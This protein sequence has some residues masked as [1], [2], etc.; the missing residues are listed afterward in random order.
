M[1]RFLF[2][3]LALTAFTLAADL[4][5]SRLKYEKEIA[6]SL[7]FTLSKVIARE[8]YQ[9][10]VNLAIS[11]DKKELSS[12]VKEFEK[13][14]KK[15]HPNALPGFEQRQTPEDAEKEILSHIHFEPTISVDS[16]SVILL[17]HKDI[18]AEKKTLATSIIKKKIQTNYGK[19]ASVEVKETA[20]DNLK[21]SKIEPVIETLTHP[22]DH[23]LFIPAIALG[24]F[25]L[26]L[27]LWLI[28][29]LRRK[30]AKLEIVNDD[31][32]IIPEIKKEPKSF[33]QS[34]QKIIDF[35]IIDGPSFREFYH[36]LPRRHQ[37]IVGLI[38][39]QTPL[40]NLTAEIAGLNFESSGEDI[41]D[42]E[43][44][45]ALNDTCSHI[46]NFR[47]LHQVVKDRPFGFVE[48]FHS[49]KIVALLAQHSPEDVA[50]VINSLDKVFVQ[51]ILKNMKLETKA[52]IL[53]ISSKP[54]LLNSL[55]KRASELEKELRLE[56][57]DE[58]F[59][60]SPITTSSLVHCIIDNDNDLSQTLAVAKLS[61]DFVNKFSLKKYLMNFEDLLS[62]DPEKI[63]ELINHLPNEIIA[64]ALRDENRSSVE[65]S[66]KNLSKL[67]RKVIDNLMLSGVLDPSAKKEAQNRFM[68]EY[69]R[70]M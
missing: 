26:L 13:S 7:E 56:I 59:K 68:K 45:I 55:A 41:S 52:K 25:L 35:A 2:I 50:I 34:I 38:L 40:T 47:R 28:Y 58:K 12:E 53:E 19:A 10:I 66:L 60:F 32:K 30:K 57:L 18:D 70:K 3:I 24:A 20:F 48:G 54:E 42:E 5:E 61:D 17:L 67:R 63:A 16:I 43:K 64:V 51:E 22:K 6:E 29:L 49:E 46:E 62:S 21:P 8:S 39:Q 65:K 36:S 1:K 37:E 69:R 4:E 27:I 33:N 14:K 11:Q 23:K 44:E 9:V 31:L 15:K